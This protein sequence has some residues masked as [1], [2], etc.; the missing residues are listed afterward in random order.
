MLSSR[1]LEHTH[2][3]DFSLENPASGIPLLIKKR[4]WGAR[5]ARQLDIDYTSNNIVRAKFEW[6]LIHVVVYLMV[7]FLIPSLRSST[8]LPLVISLQ[9]PSNWQVD[10]KFWRFIWPA[11]VESP[12]TVLHFTTSFSLLGPS[13]SEV[14]QLSSPSHVRTSERPVRIEHLQRDRTF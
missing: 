13:T 10:S 7:I 1:N 8:N 2:G 11:L 9:K 5:T 3:Q 12:R 14:L 4:L 6:K